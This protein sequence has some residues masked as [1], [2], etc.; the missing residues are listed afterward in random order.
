MRERREEERGVRNM[1]VLAGVALVVGASIYGLWRP[2]VRISKVQAANE[3]VAAL[4][5]E[6]LQGRYY[7]VLPR[8]SFFFYPEGE[9]REAVMTEHPEVVSVSVSREGFDTLSITTSER[10]A[11]MRWCGTPGEAALGGTVCYEADADGLVFRRALEEATTTPALRVYAELDTASSTDAYPLRAKVVGSE[12][13]REVLRFVT[14]VQSL[15][16]PVRSLSIRGDEADL[17]TEGGTRLTYVIGAEAEARESAQASF[18]KLNLL[19]GS[20][21]YVDLRFPGK[22]YVKRAGE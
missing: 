5:K 2:E 10:R 16:V 22:V 20:V 19:D 9:I 6:K 21:E 15:S 18:S 8:D 12:R 11:S 4:A 3:G 14:D 1:L 7:Q 13:M 17:Y